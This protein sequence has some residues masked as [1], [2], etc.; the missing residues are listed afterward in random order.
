MAL[1]EQRST[2]ISRQTFLA[3]KVVP[4]NPNDAHYG[5][6]CTVCWESYDDQHRG[7]RVLPCNHVFG[8]DCLQTMVMKTDGH[9]CPLCRCTLFRPSLELAVSELLRTSLRGELQLHALRLEDFGF[10]N[11]APPTMQRL[12]RLS[13]NIFWFF[14]IHRTPY[15][16]AAIIVKRYTDLKERVPSL[17]LWKPVLVWIIT[18]NIFYKAIR[19]YPYYTSGISVCPTATT[20]MLEIWLSVGV[21]LYAR[22]TGLDGVFQRKSTIFSLIMLVSMVIA[23]MQD[24]WI[25]RCVYNQQDPTWFT[26]AV[27]KRSPVLGIILAV[28]GW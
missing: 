27:Y 16:W 9:L 1:L 10:Y 4:A 22:C 13:V 17:D 19:L 12:M 28:A 15:Y 7:V 6:R 11:T 24:I 2:G 25:L 5:D 8:A 14:Y 26:G 20:S 21:V 18:R 23:H 3:E